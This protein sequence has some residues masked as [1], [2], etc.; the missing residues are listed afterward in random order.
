VLAIGLAAPM[1]VWA[2]DSQ[3]QEIQDD[4]VVTARKPLDTQ[5]ARRFVA[6]ISAQTQGQIARF[7][8]DVCPL[9]IGFK[10]ALKE[11]IDARIRRV[12]KAIGAGVAKPDCRGNVVLVA[13]DAGGVLVQRLRSSRPD[14][15]SGMQPAEIRRLARSAGPVRS[16]ATTAATNEDGQRVGEAKSG[17]SKDLP[18]LYVQSAS[19]FAPSSKQVIEASVVVVDTPVTL[20]KTVIQLADYATMRALAR[21]RPVE[22]VEGIGTILTLF[23]SATPPQSVTDADVAYLT[24]LYAMPGTRSLNYQVG[25]IAKGVKGASA[26]K[27]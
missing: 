22:D 6:R 19:I 16:W 27:P 17:D 11:Q 4:V 21:T 23:D 15:F 5:Q 20:G 18:K 7:D 10:P 14:L 13:T 9:V 3:P 2:Q 12:A 24:A 25:R 8:A 26:P 1:S